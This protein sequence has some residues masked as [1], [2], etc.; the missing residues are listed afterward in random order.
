MDRRQ[1]LEIT[2]ATLG[3]STRA[4]AAAPMPMAT[5]GRSGLRVSRYTLGGYHMRANGRSAGDAVL[6]GSPT[7]G[8]R[9]GD[10]A[11]E[12]AVTRPDG[13]TY[14][15]TDLDGQPVRLADLR[16]KVV[17]LN[18]WA[19]W[20]PPCQ[21]ETPILREL[22]ERYSDRGLEVIGI[23]VQETTAADVKAYA[24][25][26]D[27]RYTIGFDALGRRPARVQGLR[28]ADPVL[29]RPE[30]RHPAGRQ[31]PGRRAARGGADRVDAAA[32]AGRAVAS[33]VA[34]APV[35]AQ[36]GSN[37]KRSRS[38]DEPADRVLALVR[39]D[40]R[41]VLV[42][43]L[44][45]QLGLDLD[46]VEREVVERGH[47]A[48]VRA[49]RPHAQVAEE[50]RASGRRRPPRTT[51]AWWP[52]EWPPVG[53]TDTPG[54]HLALAVGPALARPSRGRAASSGWT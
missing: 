34:R 52:A 30:R 17:W 39:Q 28:A 40:D 38:R 25:R 33:P 42:G 6:I 29:H 47:P 27:L 50:R 54:Q 26:Y 31:R 8:L 20:C 9:P 1:F 21:H 45:E 15:L 41:P 44:G 35:R 14:Q 24:D 49:P 48:R 7:Q 43:G 46:R 3:M 19:S 53:T 37:R 22:S 5:L 12:L 11:P 51:I 13:T 23:S 10:L 16:G 18:F 2:A 36:I 32:G 4:L